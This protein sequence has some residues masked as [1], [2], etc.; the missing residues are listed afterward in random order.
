MYLDMSSDQDGGREWAEA[1]FAAVDRQDA[2]AFSGFFAPDGVF[3]F[4]NGAEVRGR[5]AIRTA[6][7]GFFDAIAGLRHEI[8]DV[9]MCGSAVITRIAVTYT[10]L[11]GSCVT[12][13]GANIWTLRDGGIG[14]YRIYIDLAPLFAPSRQT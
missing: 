10:R 12:L 13:P 14:D 9:W 1:V 5:D 2:D 11:D 3:V 8:V 4:G 7:A 6:V